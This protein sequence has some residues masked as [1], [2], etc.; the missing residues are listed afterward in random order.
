MT[1]GGNLWLTAGEVLEPPGKEPSMKVLSEEKLC[2]YMG[3]VIDLSRAILM[4]I[5]EKGTDPPDPETLKSYRGIV[6]DLLD[7]RE[8]DTYLQDDSWNWIWTEREDGNLIQ[9]YGR[10][11]WINLQLLELL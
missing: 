5:P 9:I 4:L 1:A 6:E 7:E 10:L 8:Q 3:R 2:R 11:A